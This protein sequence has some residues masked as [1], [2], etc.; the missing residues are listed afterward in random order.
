MTSEN[1]ICPECGICTKMKRDIVFLQDDIFSIIE[2]EHAR[3]QTCKSYKDGSTLLVLKEHRLKLINEIKH[4]KEEAYK[5]RCQ[6]SIECNNEVVYSLCASCVNKEW[7][8][9]VKIRDERIKELEEAIKDFLTVEDS[10][11]CCY[12]Y[13]IEQ[14]RKVVNENGRI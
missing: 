6:G 8:E 14:L 2:D 7:H 10:E 5:Y 1:C 9:L 4:L 3:C 11:V 12:D 13:E